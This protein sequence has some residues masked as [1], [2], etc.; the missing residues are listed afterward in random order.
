MSDEPEPEPPI[1][2]DAEADADATR[3][4]ESAPPKPRKKKKKKKGGARAHQRPA[5]NARGRLRPGFLL[6][7]PSDPELERIMAAYEAGNYAYVREHATELAER[8]EDPAVRA[9]ALELRRRIDPDPL[10]KY[11]L[12]AAMTLLAFLIAWA[13][14]AP[15]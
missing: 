4:S 11:L 8:T 15:H 9:A 2:G 3:S 6:D 14:L 5:L 12:L 7:F 13:Y 1:E 10:A